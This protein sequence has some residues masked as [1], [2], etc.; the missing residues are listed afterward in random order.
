MNKLIF[1]SQ[2]NSTLK[3]KNNSIIFQSINESIEN[4]NEVNNNFFENYGWSYYKQ[5]IPYYCC[6]IDEESNL[7]IQIEL[8]GFKKCKI[9]YTTLIDFYKFHIYAER[10]KNNNNNKKIILSNIAD[11]DL[12]F[13]FKIPINSFCFSNN[14][15]DSFEN[16]KGLVT[17]KYKPQIFNSLIIE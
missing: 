5:Y 4:N 10:I 7:N 12:N 8:I 9:S 13:Y 16:N 6:F 2:N 17:F 3:I 1:G 15:Y 14:K 11:E